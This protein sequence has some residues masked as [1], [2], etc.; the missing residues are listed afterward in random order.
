MTNAL[1]DLESTLQQQIGEVVLGVGPAVRALCIAVV[2]RGHVLVQGVP[3]LGKTLL[4]KSLAGALGGTFKRVQGTSDLMPTDIT[5]THLFDG[6]KNAFVFRP[7]PLFADVVLFDEVNRAGP[8]TQSALLEA[9]EERQVSVDREMF[10]LPPDFLVIATQ[11]PREFEGTY[12]LPESQ[13]DRFMLR[14]ELSYPAL[15][16]ETEVLLRYTGVAAEPAR[17]VAQAV[18]PGLVQDARAVAEQVH[19]SPQLCAYVLAVAR[20]SREHAQLSLGLSTRGAL[21][22]MRAARILA[23]I[24]GAQFVTPDD[25]KAVAPMVLPHRLMLTGD[26]LLADVSESDVVARILEQVP[27]P[28]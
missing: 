2:A 13:L 28:R 21:A 24:Q 11:N 22:L 26:A 18:P 6:V 17:P 19:I 8:R 15:E 5:G 3:G 9:M 14:L 1:H 7:G 16:A 27:A 25:V 12:P 4:S 23:G 10:A 20:A